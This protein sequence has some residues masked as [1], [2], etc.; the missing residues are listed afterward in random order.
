MDA[1]GKLAFCVCLRQWFRLDDCVLWRKGFDGILTVSY[2]Y[3]SPRGLAV[4]AHTDWLC[5]NRHVIVDKYLPIDC[6]NTQPDKGGFRVIRTSTEPFVTGKALPKKRRMLRKKLW[7]ERSKLDNPLPPQP[8]LGD[9][10]EAATVVRIPVVFMGFLLCTAWFQSLSFA[11]VK[12]LCICISYM[13]MWCTYIVHTSHTCTYRQKY[14]YDLISR[15][16]FL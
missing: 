9:T 15:I 3:L 6:G 1:R 7:K 13:C 5:L 16:K 8:N 14:A 11:Y 4:W 10:G 12:Q 2:Q